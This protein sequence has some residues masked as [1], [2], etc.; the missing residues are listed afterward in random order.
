MKE[1]KW[2]L[3][4]H[5]LP[6]KPNLGIMMVRRRVANS[7]NNHHNMKMERLSKLLLKL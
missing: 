2:D 4:M 1:I 7:G 5:L 6:T 3:Q